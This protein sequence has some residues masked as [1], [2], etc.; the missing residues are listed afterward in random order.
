MMEKVELMVKQKREE[1]INEMVKLRE[2]SVEEPSLSFQSSLSSQSFQSFKSC[3]EELL[4]RRCDDVTEDTDGLHITVEAELEEPTNRSYSS[5]E[6]Y[7]KE[8]RP[9][10]DHSCAHFFVKHQPAMTQA[11]ILRWTPPNQQIS[12]GN[13]IA[14]IL[15]M[16]GEAGWMPGH[17]MMRHYT[18]NNQNEFWVRDF[19]DQNG[20]RDYKPGDGESGF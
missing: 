3:E 18:T 19:Q 16:F 7:I 11:V 5:E 14:M 1:Q 20:G 15:K 6:G 2:D 13:W 9:E 12:E 8:G 4:L 10:M 17:H